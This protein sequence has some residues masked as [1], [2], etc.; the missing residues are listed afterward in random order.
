MICCVS[1]TLGR[2]W[3]PR[4]EATTRIRIFY[5]WEP[6]VTSWRAG[7]QISSSEYI[8]QQ[9][10]NGKYFVKWMSETEKKATHQ[11][12]VRRN[13]SSSALFLLSFLQRLLTSCR[14]SQ[15]NHVRSKK[16]KIKAFSQRRFYR[17]RLCQYILWFLLPLSSF[18]IFPR[19]QPEPALKS[20]HRWKNRWNHFFFS[21]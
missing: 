5:V 13:I 11:L 8:D 7:I 1:H 21:F 10:K 3:Q 19:K 17:V 9:V 12:I 18:I 16:I 15:K 20:T 6:T 4:A 14:G 2:R